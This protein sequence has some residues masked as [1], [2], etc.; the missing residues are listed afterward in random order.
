MEE[1]NGWMQVELVAITPDPEQLIARCARVSRRKDPKSSDPD[2]D[3]RL[4]ERL[5]KAGHLST[6]EHAQ[7]TF[8]V[9]GISRVCLAQL[10]RHRHLSFTVESGRFTHAIPDNTVFPPTISQ[11]ANSNRKAK[12]VYRKAMEAFRISFSTYFDLI[13]A[14]IPL[15]DARFILPLGMDTRLALSGNLRAFY[16]FIQKRKGKDAQWEIRELA[17]RIAK[18][19]TQYAPSIFRSLCDEE[20]AHEGRVQGS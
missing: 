8:M 9:S 7:A 17:L 20:Y 13:D 16:E 15:E 12:E 18:I 6:L 1:K 3:R 2:S 11:L 10:T 4:V 19:L 5:V 14:G